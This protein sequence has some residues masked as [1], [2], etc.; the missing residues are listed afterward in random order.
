MPVHIEK[1]AWGGWP[2]C[3]RISNGEVELV[4]TTDVGPRIMSFRFAGGV[5]LFKV[6]EEQLG[7]SG[8]PGWQ[9]RGGHRIWLAPEDRFASYA[10]DNLPAEVSIEGGVL[11]A[12]QP[13]EPESGLRKQ[14]SIRMADAGTSVEVLHRMQNCRETPFRFAAWAL[15]IMSAGGIAVTG[16]PPRGSHAEILAPTNPLVMWAFTDLSDPRWG[17][18]EKYLVLR[19]DPAN[20]NHTKLGHFNAKTWGAYFLNGDLFVKRYDADPTR[21]YPDFGCSYE[22][23]ACADMLELETLGPLETV[24]PN[25]WLEHVETWSLHKAEL[26]SPTSAE[27]DR[28]LVPILNPWLLA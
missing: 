10:A 18:L 15:S 5:N 25:A 16:F 26:K 2:N 19:Q 3:Y 21:E 7:K 20:A 27:F 6:V 4:V 1:V 23:F 24:A 9:M 14:I 17:L 11:T 22:T 13:V 28:I 8:E 12:T